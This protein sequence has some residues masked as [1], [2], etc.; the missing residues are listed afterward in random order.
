LTHD[1][2]GNTMVTSMEMLVWWVKLIHSSPGLHCT[3]GADQTEQELPFPNWGENWIFW[4]GYCR[5][6]KGTKEK[7][8]P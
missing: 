2:Q 3:G 8:W 7:C 5:C 1:G 4:I 6:T